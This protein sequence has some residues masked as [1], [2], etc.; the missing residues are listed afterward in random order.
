METQAVLAPVQRT[1]TVPLSLNHAFWR[2]TEQ[3][4][5]WWPTEHT[6]AGSNLEEIGIEPRVGGMVYERGRHGFCCA[7]GE[8]R[9][10]E[11]PERLVLA[12]TFGADPDGAFDPAHASEVDIRFQPVSNCTTQV[13]LSHRSFERLGP[14]GA[15]YRDRMD[16]PAGWS[17]ILKSYA[18]V[19]GY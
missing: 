16:G 6:W 5:L 9:V 1:V 2:F 17:R 12:W 14:D 11:P 8:V 7:M 3:M 18:R 10:W 15:A 4:G 19:D 13:T